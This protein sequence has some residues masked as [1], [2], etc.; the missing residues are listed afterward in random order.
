MA[1]PCSRLSP[2]YIFIFLSNAESIKR[3]A[4]GNLSPQGN[5]ADSAE[6][7]GS[8]QEQGSEQETHNE[9]PF[10]AKHLIAFTLWFR[11]CML[12]PV[13]HS[14]P[15]PGTL[16]ASTLK[17]DSAKYLD[18]VKNHLYAR[19]VSS[20]YRVYSVCPCRRTSMLNIPCQPSLYVAA[21][22]ETARPVRCDCK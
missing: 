22:V 14:P 1:C 18:V 7:W 3:A 10:P 20:G 19:P 2:R 9:N 8:F 4:R 21:K 11:C 15:A 5:T 16:C 6:S 13:Y 17:P 12:T